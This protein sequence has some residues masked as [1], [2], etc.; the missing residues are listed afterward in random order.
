MKYFRNI[1][2]KYGWIG[3]L[4]PLIL[5]NAGCGSYQKYPVA[6]FNGDGFADKIYVEKTNGSQKFE[7]IFLRMGKP[8]GELGE[9]IRVERVPGKI[10]YIDVVDKN[11]DNN[12]VVTF[13]NAKSGWK[14]VTLSSNGK[15]K[16]KATD[17]PKG[18]MP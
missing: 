5:F 10:S 14:E 11:G 17:E 7:D 12:L 16:F 3:F 8:D 4:S 15:G 2:E 1:L 18:D 6:D 13:Y 9:S